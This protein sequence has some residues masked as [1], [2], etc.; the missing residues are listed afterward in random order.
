MRRLF[1]QPSPSQPFSS[2]CDHPHYSKT[3]CQFS[4]E[5][6]TPHGESSDRHRIN[7]IRFTPP[8]DSSEESYKKVVFFNPQEELLVHTVSSS[9]TYGLGYVDCSPILEYRRNPIDKIQRHVEIPSDSEI[10]AFLKIFKGIGPYDPDDQWKKKMFNWDMFTHE[11]EHLYFEEVMLLP[12]DDRPA[13]NRQNVEKW[14]EWMK[15]ENQWISFYEW[16]YPSANIIEQSLMKQFRNQAKQKRIKDPEKFVD[17][18]LKENPVVIP[19]PLKAHVF[20][21]KIQSMLNKPNIPRSLIAVQIEGE[22]LLRKIC[23]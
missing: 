8:S 22:K 21:P 16:Y 11:K 14:K 10:I 1:S 9:S 5:P 20:Q 19:P 6:P 15:A 7:M 4:S 23:S 3:F 17:E 12:R 18:K 2:V 13:F